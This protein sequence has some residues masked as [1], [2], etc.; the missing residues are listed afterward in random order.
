M[1]ACQTLDCVSVFALTVS[2]AWTVYQAMAGFDAEDPWSKSVSVGHPAA[3]PPVRR[4][5]VP[6]RA[7]RIFL[8]DARAEAAFDQALSL[9]RGAGHTLV[10]VDLSP[11]FETAQLLY[12]GAWVA[13]R[14]QAVRGFIGTHASS[15][16]PTTLA[17]TRGAEQL[18]AADAFAGLY[19][20]A[21]LRRRTEPLWATVD[22][23]AVPTFPRPV[24]LAEIAADPLGPNSGLGTYTNFVNLLD[25]CALAVPGPFRDDGRPAGVTLIA[26][27]GHD[28]DIAGVGA[29]LHR[30][31]KV[32][33]GATGVAQPVAATFPDVSPADLIDIVA[34]GAHLSGLPLNGELVALGATFVKAVETTGDYALYALPGTVPPKPGLVRVADGTGRAIAT[35]VWSLT[36][37]AF[38]HFV[39]RIPPPLGIGTI[40]LADGTAAKGFLCE[41]AALAGADDISHHGGWRA[42]LR[43][44]GA[45]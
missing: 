37:D 20:L 35:E 24:T 33:L 7:S 42:F 8:G 30:A 4:I 10:D 40:R 38:G 11:F 6:D 23:L 26:P 12:A 21:A 32:T 2:E 3:E 29:E 28:A 25:L 41:P 1:P 39:N 43:A 16:H 14:Y 17:I 44:K 22:M 5:G 9:L 45:P 19:R 27:A 31:T 13:E 36:P 34:V 18:T 15:M